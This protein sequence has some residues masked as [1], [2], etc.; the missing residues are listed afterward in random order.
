M[1][2]YAAKTS[3]A[4]ERIRPRHYGRFNVL[5]YRTSETTLSTYLSIAILISGLNSF[6]LSNPNDFLNMPLLDYS[7]VSMISV[8]S[9]FFFNISNVLPVLTAYP[10]C[11]VP[12]GSVLS[13][14]HDYRIARPDRPPSVSSSRGG[15][16]A[17]VCVGSCKRAYR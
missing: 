14:G 6:A 8:R 1:N 2:G 15:G 3:W 7:V 11:V 16:S 9:L 12:L 17:G 5:Y 13:P 4:R 10:Y